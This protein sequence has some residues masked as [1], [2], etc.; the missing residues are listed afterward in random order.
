VP[1]G[2]LTATSPFKRQKWTD[3]RNW[4]LLCNLGGVI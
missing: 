4:S 3:G 1:F 2:Q